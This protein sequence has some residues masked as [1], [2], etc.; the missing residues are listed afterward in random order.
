MQ[1]LV[2]L[3]VA[4]KNENNQSK[5][6]IFN[7]RKL[8]KHEK[9]EKLLNILFIFLNINNIKLFMFKRMFKL[10]IKLKIFKFVF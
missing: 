7:S 10:Y 4:N 8:F 6:E 3:N 1:E 9:I 2:N 5:H